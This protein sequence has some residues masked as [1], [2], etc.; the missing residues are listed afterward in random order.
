MFVGRG[1]AVEVT[2]AEEETRDDGNGEAGCGNEDHEMVDGQAADNLF[3][4]EMWFRSRAGDIV[5][6][7]EAQVPD[8]EHGKVEKVGHGGRARA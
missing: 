2:P 6:A 7:A 4:N 5:G 3:P 8:L 1:V